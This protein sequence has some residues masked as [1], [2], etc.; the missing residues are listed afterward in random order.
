MVAGSVFG[1]FVVIVAGSNIVVV[2]ALFL[3]G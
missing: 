1:D 2:I 3:F